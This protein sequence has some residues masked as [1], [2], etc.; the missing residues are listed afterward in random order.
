VGDVFVLVIAGHLLGDFVAQTDWQASHKESSWRADLAHVLTY[1][2]TLA[3]LVLP[4]WHDWRAMWFFAISAGTHAFIDRRWPTRL[5]LGSTGSKN[6]ATVFWG[7][8]ATDQ[9]LHLSI[10]AISFYWLS[11]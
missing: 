4:A 11:R 10:L 1:H 3:A 6:F 5:L 8:I 9:A 2:L 7:V